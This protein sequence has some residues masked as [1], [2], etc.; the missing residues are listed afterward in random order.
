M[1]HEN[2]EK[3]LYDIEYGTEEQAEE[4]RKQLNFA[5]RSD[6]ADAAY[7][8]RGRDAQETVVKCFR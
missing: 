6:A 3:L 2:E 5:E 1:S 7:A 4:A 8:R